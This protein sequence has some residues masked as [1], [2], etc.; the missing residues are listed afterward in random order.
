VR[1]TCSTRVITS[2]RPLSALTTDSVM[3]LRCSRERRAVLRPAASRRRH[4]CRRGRSRATAT[5]RTERTTRAPISCRPFD[6]EV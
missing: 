6:Q 3:S 5:G 1:L 2:F 4:P